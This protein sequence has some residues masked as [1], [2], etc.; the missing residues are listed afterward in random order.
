MTYYRNCEC[1]FHSVLGVKAAGIR[2]VVDEFCEPVSKTDADTT[3]EQRFEAMLS[4][5]AKFHEKSSLTKAQIS[6]IRS[7]PVIPIQAKGF[8]LGGSLSG[9]EMR[10]FCDKDWYIPDRVT[11]EAALRGKVNMLVLRV[12]AAMRL[13]GLLE[14]LGCR[15]KFLS[16]AVTRSVRPHGVAVPD[17]HEEKELH[18]R[19][20]YVSRYGKPPSP[21]LKLLLT[22]E[23]KLTSLVGSS[24]VALVTRC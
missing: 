6:R 19:L 2:H 13:K 24:K 3:I 22:V 7:A 18:G 15:E 8:A 21:V 4:L 17:P 5:L 16:E 1:L 10:S 12:Q 20:R 11:F 9:T 14:D 23:L